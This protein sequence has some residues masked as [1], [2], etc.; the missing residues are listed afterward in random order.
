[1]KSFNLYLYG[2]TD[3]RLSVHIPVEEQVEMAI[4]GGV[5]FI[6]LREKN[7][8]LEEYIEK[9]KRV[10]AVCDKYGVAFVINDNVRAAKEVD[11]SGVHIGQSD[12]DMKRAREVL[13]NEKI[14]GVSA[15]TVEEAI[16]AEKDGAD[17]IGI[18]AVFSTGTKRDVDTIGV[19]KLRKVANSVK[20]PSVAIGGIKADNAGYLADTGIDGIAVV[21]A[22]F[23][24]D[25]ITGAAKELS[26]WRKK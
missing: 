14:I 26:S 24:S 2:V 17:Y 12:M 1:M 25:D 21:S 11:C 22:I 7:I 20:I 19:E 18:G 3:P 4:R 6:Q 8:S 13:G 5:T 9:G 23:G 16:K 10:K 15:G